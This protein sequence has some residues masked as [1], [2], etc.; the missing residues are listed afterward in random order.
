MSGCDILKKLEELE[1]VKDDIVKA[2]RDESTVTTWSETEVGRVQSSLQMWW[3]RIHNGR[4]K[5]MSC[6]LL[7]Y[8][9]RIFQEITFAKRWFET[10]NDY[11]E[12]AIYVESKP[13]AVEN[14]SDSD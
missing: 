1:K 4:F 2:E 8:E 7:S 14:D 5:A 12:P 3:R 11:R 10:S 6:L 13:K 9:I